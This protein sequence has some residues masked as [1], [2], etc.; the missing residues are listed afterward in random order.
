MNFD[1]DNSLVL[2][3]NEV[4]SSMFIHVL[5]SR[6]TKYTKFEKHLPKLDKRRH[7]LLSQWLSL[8]ISVF[9]FSRLSSFL[10][11]SS[12]HLLINCT[13]F[14][15]GSIFLSSFCSR[16]SSRSSRV[17]AISL[18]KSSRW[19]AHTVTCPDTGTFTIKDA[20]KATGAQQEKS[21]YLCI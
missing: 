21:D 18:T 19:I 17:N 4:I 13:V 16:I 7:S 5:K 12:N 14:K 3:A 10:I 9:S 15:I 20:H 2:G 1:I 8:K 6:Q 11:I